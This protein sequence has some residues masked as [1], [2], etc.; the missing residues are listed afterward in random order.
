[1]HSLTV[2]PTGASAPQVLYAAALVPV[3]LLADKADR[4]RLLA[5]GI[6]AWSVLTMAASQVHRPS[7]HVVCRPRHH[8]HGH[9]CLCSALALHPAAKAISGASLRR[10]TAL[11]RSSS[12][13]SALRLHRLLRTLSA[14]VSA[15][16]LMRYVSEMDGSKLTVQDMLI[17]SLTHGSCVLAGLIPELFPEQRTTAMAAYNSAIYMGRALSFGAVILAGQ[18]GV[19]TGDIGIRMVSF[20]GSC[21]H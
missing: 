18:L 8:D 19:P 16:C 17:I 20:C 2:L 6:A 7:V 1:M 15:V 21:H 4:P 9:T 5:A 14:S 3:G 12:C 10:S 13:G 11:Q